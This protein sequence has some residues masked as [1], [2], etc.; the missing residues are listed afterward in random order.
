MTKRGVIRLFSVAAGASVI[1]IAK[2]IS[3]KGFNSAIEK[4][5]K[6]RSEEE[7]VI[8][9]EYET[10]SKAANDILRREEDTRELMESTIRSAYNRANTITRNI[11]EKEKAKSQAEYR[12][13]SETYDARDAEM[14]KIKAIEE[15]TVKD[16]L[17]N[18]DA[19][20]ALKSARKVLKKEEKSTDKIDAKMANRKEAIMNSVISGRTDKAKKLFEEADSIKKQMYDSDGRMAAIVANRTDDEK[21]LF[22][23]LERCKEDLYHVKDIKKEI[24]DKRSAK[25]KAVFEKKSNL[26]TKISEIK[27]TERTNI[28]SRKAFTDELKSMGFGKVSV[29]VV[30][31][32][33]LVPVG[34]LT[35]D[36]ISWL[37]NF[38]KSM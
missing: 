2:Y 31:L 13:L 28:D 10:V 18:D 35:F 19:Y 32:I 3:N 26:A 36:Y 14:S 16:V 7:K 1:C 17:K 30:G 34:I 12:T 38:T 33:P 29:F 37:I 25:D 20:Q 6:N 23:Q 5:A 4:A 24:I 15:S 9:D 8:F 22:K 21:E 11:L 27:E